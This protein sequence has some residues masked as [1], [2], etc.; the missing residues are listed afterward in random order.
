MKGG[1]HA[2]ATQAVER[3][4]ALAGGDGERYFAA[5]LH[6]LHGELLARSPHHQIGEAPAAFRTALAIAGEQ[7]AQ[8]LERKAQASLRRWCG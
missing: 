6:R 3:G 8:T 5:E 4:I 7:G 1:H 2:E